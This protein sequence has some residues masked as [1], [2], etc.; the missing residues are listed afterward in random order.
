M[1]I[2]TKGDQSGMKGSPKSPVSEWDIMGGVKQVL[3]PRSRF[4]SFP[5][6]NIVIAYVLVSRADKTSDWIQGP[7]VCEN[8]FATVTEEHF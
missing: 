3:Y 4:E 7:Y 8:C 1:V 6:P 5:D 2:P